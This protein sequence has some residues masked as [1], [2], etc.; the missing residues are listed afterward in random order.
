VPQ[1]SYWHEKLGR[2]VLRDERPAAKLEA[3]GWEVAVVWECET[4]D[5]RTLRERLKSFLRDVA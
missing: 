2:N 5:A 1:R 3:M 4:R